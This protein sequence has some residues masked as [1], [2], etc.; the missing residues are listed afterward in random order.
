MALIESYTCQFCN[1]EFKREGSLVVHLC[2]QKRRFNSKDD[3]G[4]KL[5]LL[6]Y[7][8]FYQYT[9]DRTKVKT[10]TEFAKSPY[11]NAFVKFG[12]Y[13]INTH[14][15]KVDKFIDYVIRSGIKLDNWATDK[16]YSLFLSQELRTEPVRDALA[17]S[18][19]FSIH[20][21]NEKNIQPEDILRYGNTNM[22][23]YA[24]STGKLSPW[25]VYNSGSGQQFLSKLPE[26]QMKM[27]WD[28]IDPDFWLNRFDKLADD[29][30]WS[31]E[32]LKNAGW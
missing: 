14:C 28:F 32:V 11:Y 5:A 18:I 17:R 29:V 26:H 4:V 16:T 19:E 13:C 12:N 10:F 25:A 21:S 27:I 31:Q 23:T 24:I 22:I 8:K 7:I 6:T 2:E 1:K 3:K 9:Q 15:I 20:W 30:A